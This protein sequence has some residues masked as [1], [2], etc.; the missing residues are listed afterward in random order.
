MPSSITHND[1]HNITF[2][3]G[4]GVALTT[5][6]LYEYEIGGMWNEIGDNGGLGLINGG[7]VIYELDQDNLYK[8]EIIYTSGANTIKK[9]FEYLVTDNAETII[10]NLLTKVVCNCNDISREKQKVYFQFNRTLMFIASSIVYAWKHHGESTSEYIDAQ[11][12][13]IDQ[14]NTRLN[15]FYDNCEFDDCVSNTCNCQ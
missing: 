13:S 15:N 10:S 11:L 3:N 1:T 5:I 8:V 12:A 4:E 14:I 2:T 7:S 6:K 9:E